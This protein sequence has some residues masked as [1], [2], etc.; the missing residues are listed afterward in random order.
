MTRSTQVCGDFMRL[1]Y[2]GPQLRAGQEL[3][4]RPPLMVLSTAGSAAVGC[5]VYAGR[6]IFWEDAPFVEI[7]TYCASL[8]LA[9]IW[10]S[11][12]SQKVMSESSPFIIYLY[13]CFYALAHPP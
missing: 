12:V 9:F 13:F 11:E 10:H 6:A 4:R 3:R 5:T 8:C 7:P 1:V 2:D